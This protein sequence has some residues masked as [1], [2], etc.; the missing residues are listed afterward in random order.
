MGGLANRSYEQRSSD[1]PRET[2]GMDDRE[3]I[4]DLVHRL[5]D[6]ELAVLLCLVADGH[7][8]LTSEENW[9]A[10]LAAEVEGV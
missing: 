4:S 7:C 10:R 2:N 6:V 1:L 5:N 9:L 8:I 3:S